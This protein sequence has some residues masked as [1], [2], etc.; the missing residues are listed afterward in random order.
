MTLI[1]LGMKLIPCLITFILRRMKLIPADQSFI[2]CL[3][4]VSKH[5]VSFIPHTQS[6]KVRVHNEMRLSTSFSA[7]LISERNAVTKL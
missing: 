5:V 1:T 7:L 6:F 2:P 4:N 3:A